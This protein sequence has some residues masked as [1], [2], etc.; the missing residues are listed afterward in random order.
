MVNIMYA[1]GLATQWVTQCGNK[2]IQG[3][4]GWHHGCWCYDFLH[5]QAIHTYGINHTGQSSPC[6][7]KILIYSCNFSMVT[8]TWMI[9]SYFRKNKLYFKFVFIKNISLGDTCWVQRAVSIV[10]YWCAGALSSMPNT[11]QDQMSP[12]WVFILKANFSNIFPWIR[13]ELCGFD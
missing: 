6:C 13:N 12:L 3:N 9:R 1:D 2:N 10:Q 5:H 8:E 4:I 11:D 7:W